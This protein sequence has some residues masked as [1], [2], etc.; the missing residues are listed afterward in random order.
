MFYAFIFSKPSKNPFQGSSRGKEI[1]YI[2]L[3]NV[4]NKII[5]NLF[6]M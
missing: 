2:C 5:Q 6:Q 4:M 1:R 3:E